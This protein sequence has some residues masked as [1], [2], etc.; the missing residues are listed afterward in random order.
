MNNGIYYLAS[1]SIVFDGCC[2]DKMLRIK[3]KDDRI[4]NIDFFKEE[5]ES[6]LFV[7][8]EIVINSLNGYKWDINYPEED[9]L[10][11]LD[12]FVSSKKFEIK[13]KL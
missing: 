11:K 6:T 2:I 8:K 13:Y 3:I 4:L 1:H 10:E 12:E 5:C 7:N 9:L